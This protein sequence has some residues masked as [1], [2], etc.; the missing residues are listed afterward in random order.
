MKQRRFLIACLVV[1][2][3]WMAACGSNQAGQSSP[4]STPSAGTSPP[5]TDTVPA[6]ARLGCGKLCQQAGPPAG[7]DAPGCP[8]GDSDKCAPCPTTGCA[9]VGA[10]SATV[11]DGAFT[12]EM[13]C[14]VDHPCA[15]ALIVQIPV[16]LA[17]RVAGSD[18]SVPAGEARRVTV[19]LTPFGR[20]VVGTTGDF[21]GDL[22]LFLEGSGQDRLGKAGPYA[23]HA[24]V[25]LHGS[26]E[27][28]HACGQRITATPNTSC[29]FAR[30]IAATFAER[31]TSDG[32]IVVWSPVTKRSYRMTCW[33]DSTTVSCGGGHDA[34]AAFPDP[35]R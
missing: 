6:S 21:T 30:N 32:W 1:A 17:G 9:E 12:M 15:G 31:G 10:E 26:R 28:M 34:F 24:S 35:H 25:H 13:R 23:G 5:V 7:D 19:E 20:H 2:A 27:S 18:V 8:D 33:S 29:E 11:S 22:Y 3:A 14:L 16:T 4:P